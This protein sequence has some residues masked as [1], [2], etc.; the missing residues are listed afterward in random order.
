[1]YKKFINTAFLPVQGE[2]TVL[3][4]ETC[5]FPFSAAEEARASAARA[6][7]Q[8]LKAIRIQEEQRR[9]EQ[10]RQHQEELRQI[11]ISKANFRAEQERIRNQRM[12][13]LVNCFLSDVTQLPNLPSVKAT[14]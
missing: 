6:E 13:V 12:Q 11:E 2:G 4:L 8:R 1:M 10:E 14:V 9:A 5:D 7:A 3:S